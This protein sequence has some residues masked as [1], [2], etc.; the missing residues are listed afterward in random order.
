MTAQRAP[1]ATRASF[2]LAQCLLG[3]V[4]VAVAVLLLN[5]AFGS[6]ARGRPITQAWVA[7]VAALMLFFPGLVV[8]ARAIIEVLS[9][10]RDEQ[11]NGPGGPAPLGFV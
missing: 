10:R 1:R 4:L 3:L 7:G 8:L 2:P 6:M 9:G 5:F 11:R